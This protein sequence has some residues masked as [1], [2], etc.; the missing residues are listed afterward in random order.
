M[1]GQKRRRSRK[2]PLMGNHQRCW[3][4][5]R[6]VV[7]ETLLAGRWPIIELRMSAG[8]SEEDRQAVT[9][10]AAENEIPVTVEPAPRLA[11][12][13][14]ATDHQGLLAKMPPFPY[15]SLAEVISVGAGSPA[16]VLLDRVQDPHNFGAIIRAADVLGM[17]GLIVGTDR[18]SEVTSVVARSSAG[19]VNHLPIARVTN[20]VDAVQECRRSG[21]SVVAADAGAT[22]DLAQQ[23]LSVPTLFVLGNEH[24][25]VSGSLLALSQATVKIPQT[26][27]IESL[28]VAVAAGICFY[29]L[30][31][32][33]AGSP[34]HD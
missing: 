12:L 3:L 5:G 24:A 34:S 21:F 33:R 27:Q 9:G 15:S 14:G 28:N 25:G 29:E 17:D 32:Q 22:N 8:L 20:L 19:A 4:W 26:G 1:V 7:L 2:S 31:R 23:D 18:Q 11:Q 6:H 13:C 16:L 10:L 30:R